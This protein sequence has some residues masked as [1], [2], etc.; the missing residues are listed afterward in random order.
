MTTPPTSPPAREKAVPATTSA[1]AVY[2]L[3]L[4]GAAVYFVQHASTI[5]M[6]VL[7]ILEAIVWPAIIVYKILEL[8]H[9]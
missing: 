2:G 7:G 5:W 3:G 6:G 4:I 8:L 1:N 9:L